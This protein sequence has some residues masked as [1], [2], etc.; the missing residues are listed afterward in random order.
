MPSHAV[1]LLEIEGPEDATSDADMDGYKY[2][3]CGIVLQELAPGKLLRTSI[4]T[5][6]LKTKPEVERRRV[7]WLVL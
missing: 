3:I 6:L 5:T 1:C 2:A 7:N 4:F